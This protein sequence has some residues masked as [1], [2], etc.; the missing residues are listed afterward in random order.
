V[1]NNIFFHP[2]NPPNFWNSFANNHDRFN[3]N[4]IVIGADAANKSGAFYQVSG[5]PPEGPFVEAMD[6][7]LFFSEVGNFSARYSPRKGQAARYSLQQWQ[8]L[9]YDTH[10]LFSDP[11]FVDPGNQDY[12]VKSESPAIGLGFKNF[13][14]STAGLL[15]DFPREYLGGPAEA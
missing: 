1:E 3:R 6:Y 4:I 15:P 14:L 13:D 7:N 5:A 12:R 9:G 8:A 10:S 2:S 11:M